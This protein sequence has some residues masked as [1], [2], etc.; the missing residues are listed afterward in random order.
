[1]KCSVKRRTR[2][3]NPT[4]MLTHNASQANT[5]ARHRPVGDQL[6]R[7]TPPK[8]LTLVDKLRGVPKVQSHCLW[9]PSGGIAK[10]TSRFGP[11]WSEEITDKSTAQ[12]RERLSDAFMI[13]LGSS[14]SSVTGS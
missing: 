4:T 14:Q 5:R 1:M 9:G 11:A 6:H 10:K 13:H 2:A 7:V 8:R 3:S 12:H